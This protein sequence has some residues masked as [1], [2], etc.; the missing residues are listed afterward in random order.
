MVWVGVK[1][2]LIMVLICVPLMTNDVEPVFM[3]LLA[4]FI[5]LENSLIRFLHIFMVVFLLVSCNTSLHIL[6]TDSLSD[7]C[8][9]IFSTILWIVFIFLIVS[10]LKHKNF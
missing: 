10:F 9:Q 3:C 1:C 4:I 2:Y 7:R 8:F 6:D 5:C